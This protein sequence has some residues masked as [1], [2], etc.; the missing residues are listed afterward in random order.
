[1][2]PLYCGAVLVVGNTWLGACWLYWRT[3]EELQWRSALQARALGVCNLGAFSRIG[4]L[5]NGSD[6]PICESPFTAGVALGRMITR[7]T[8]DRIYSGISK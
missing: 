6:Y 3:E 4:C 1:M 5:D 8:A 7:C 2:F